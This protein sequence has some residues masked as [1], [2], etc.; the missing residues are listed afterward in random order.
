MQ[1]TKLGGPEL[2]Q[3]KAVPGLLDCELVYEVKGAHGHLDYHG[4]KFEPLMWQQVLAF[5]RWTFQSS[6]SESQVRL[7]VNVPLGRWAAWAFPQAAGTGLTARELAV[8]E[9]PEAAVARFAAWGTEPSGDWRYF[10]TVH[11]HCAASAFQSG[12]DE[13]NEQSQAGLHLTV[14]RL[15]AER[16]DLHARFYLNGHCFAPD[17][18]RFWPLDPELAEQLPVA[19]HDALARFQMGAPSDVEF[20]AEWRQNVRVVAPVSRIREIGLALGYHEPL[21]MEQPD[22]LRTERAWRA[23]SE[24]GAASSLT[25]EDCLYALQ[26]LLDNPALNLILRT[27]VQHQ[28]TPEELLSEAP[29]PDPGF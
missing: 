21:R 6:Q 1:L 27:C 29:F 23:L 19:L 13:A 26:G 28:L 14:G 18:S 5:F 8:P 15:D 4:P 9:S 10:G 24:A 7:Y 16:Y 3:C 25:E 11:H 17:L 12:T 2:K 20:P 22:W